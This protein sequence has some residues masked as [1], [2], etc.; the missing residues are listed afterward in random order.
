MLSSSGLNDWL[1]EEILVRLP[2]FENMIDYSADIPV[3]DPQLRWYREHSNI[4]NF[5]A[6]IPA[7]QQMRIRGEELIVHPDT[8]LKK[9]STWLRIRSDQEV[10][11]G[12]KHPERW[13]FAGLGPRNARFGGDPIF[14][15][16]P[17]LDG[18]RSRRATLDDP[19]P[20]RTGATKVK[21]GVRR[22]AQQ[23][24]YT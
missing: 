18:N 20:W 8:Y 5:L 7:S 16:N 17:A 13:I 12:M 22:L 19:L 15:R 11:E 4:L 21:P 14:S 9:I 2:Y 1:A 10:I 24:G 23:F 6:D 3:I